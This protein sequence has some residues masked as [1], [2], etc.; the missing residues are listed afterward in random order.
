MITKVVL[1]D[2]IDK[3]KLIPSFNYAIIEV[4]RYT[5]NVSGVIQNNKRYEII[6]YALVHTKQDI[7]HFINTSKLNT[8][9][10]IVPYSVESCLIH[11]M[12][13]KPAETWDNIQ[14]YVKN[15][16]W[17]IDLDAD[18]EDLFNE[19]TTRLD[20]LLISYEIFKSKRGYSVIAT[21]TPDIYPLLNDFYTSF[22]VKS[23]FCRPILLKYPKVISE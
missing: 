8:R 15:K 7:S 16:F 1:N 23:W 5:D 9:V 11:D 20:N 13:S 18:S 4:A 21:D 19:V 22:K 17:N 2:N 12:D 6:R 10:C 3:L 14:F